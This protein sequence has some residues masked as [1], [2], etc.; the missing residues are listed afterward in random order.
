M[1][2]DEKLALLR[3]EM[4]KENIDIYIIPSSDP[5]NSEYVADRWK[6]R[7][8]ISGFDGSAGTVIITQDHAGLWTDSRYYLQGEQQLSDSSFTLHKMDDQFKDYSTSFITEQL[9]NGGVV[10]YDGNTMPIG[11]HQKFQKKLKESELKFRI[12]ADLI[13]RIWSNRPSLPQKEIYEHALKYT[14]KSRK[15][16][17]DALRASFEGSDYFLVTAL[18]EIAYILNIRGSDVQSNPVAICYLLVTY[19]K[20]TL[21]IDE[22]KVPK[23]MQ[24]ILINDKVELKGYEAL[25]SSLKEISAP[26]KI[27]VDPSTCNATIYE[28]ITEA[29][30]KKVDSPIKLMKAIKNETEIAHTRNAMIKDGVALCKAFIWLE[31]TLKTEEV[32]EYQ[33]AEKIAAFRADQKLYVGESFDAIIGYKDHGAIIH[34]KPTKASSKKMIDDGL[35]LCDSGG[36]Y[37]DGTTDITRT[38]ALGKVTQEIRQNYTLVL[39]GYIALDQ[40]VFK[41]GT[42]GGQLDILARQYLWK[43]GLNYGHGTGHG[44][45]YFLNVHEPPQGFAPGNSVRARTAHVPGMMTSNEPGYYKDGAYGIRIENILLTIERED[46]FLAHETLT[47]CP[48]DTSLID[49]ILIN[50]E[51]RTWINRYHKTVYDRLSPHLDDQ[52]KRWL[53]NKCSNI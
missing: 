48:I 49:N 50:E 25:A 53:E 45:G 40:A 12:D 46:G 22:A 34:Y 8:W 26:H 24:Q 41:K 36:Q 1:R 29:E 7:E 33:F 21:F 51:E 2:V 4:S 27:S 3:K 52:E 38:M 13:Q 11:T 6:A 44:V 43:H 35:L 28:S 23:E 37:L 19:E 18:D 5:H 31:E 9:K 15:D 20:A 30:I 47:L 42:N 32:A 17:L 10:G 39:K 14:G 16:K